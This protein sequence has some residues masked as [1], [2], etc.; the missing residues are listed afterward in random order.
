M[1]PYHPSPMQGLCPICWQ[2]SLADSDTVSHS[3]PREPHALHRRCIKEWLKKYDFCPICFAQV[4]KD[5]VFSWPERCLR[6]IKTA[7]S[8]MFNGQ[9]IDGNALALAALENGHPL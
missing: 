1:E 4:D 2:D 5:S 8:G 3:G 7:A 9:P 6:H